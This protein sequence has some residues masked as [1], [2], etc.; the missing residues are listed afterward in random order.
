MTDGSL[1]FQR[2]PPQ[3]HPSSG[4]SS[5]SDRGS[6][7]PSST[8]VNTNFPEFEKLVQEAEQRLG[9]TEWRPT[10]PIDEQPM[11]DSELIQ[12][13]DAFTQ[14]LESTANVWDRI[15][16]PESY[17]RFTD[18]HTWTQD[19]KAIATTLVNMALRFHEHGP[20][21]LFFRIAY[22]RPDD[23]NSN[24]S[25]RQRLEDTRRN[26]M[27]FKSIASLV[28]DG[29]YHLE[30]IAAPR[31]VEAQVMSTIIGGPLSRTAQ[32][33]GGQ[34]AAP[35][36]QQQSKTQLST[37]QPQLP[38]PIGLASSQPPSTR[39]DNISGQRISPRPG[40]RRTAEEA[41]LDAQDNLNIQRSP[42]RPYSNA[43]WSERAMVGNFADDRN[44]PNRPAQSSLFTDPIQPIRAAQPAE[45]ASG[46]FFPEFVNLSDDEEQQ[47]IL[48][49]GGN[50]DAEDEDE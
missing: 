41:G 14:A 29:R 19:F 21:S 4:I 25:L 1:G 44:T 23:E 2:N 3:N 30:L 33:V 50:E 10:P 13:V 27:R 16:R 37:Q 35:Q 20:N 39:Q 18:G 5:L 42:Y 28:M 32:E 40:E 34:H 49:S 9:T 11:T 22:R 26:L 24:L 45:G 6:H 38:Q 46:E 15:V 43:S 47:D 8:P 7:S 48:E 36:Q 17:R 12:W 31:A